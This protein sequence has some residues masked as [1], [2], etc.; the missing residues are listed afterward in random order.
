VKGADLWLHARDFPGAYVFVK[1]RA[2][3]SV[4]LDI[5]LDA[6]NLALFYSKGRN[7]GE[8]DLYYTQVK[9]LRRSKHGPKGLV[10]PTQEKNLRV[11][12][13]PARLKILEGCREE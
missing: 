2:G 11:K 7:A 4:P 10:L 6:G 5:L 9:F 1:A 12:A 13:D 8:A 3:K